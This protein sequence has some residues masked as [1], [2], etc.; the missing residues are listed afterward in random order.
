[1]LVEDDI[2]DLRQERET[3]KNKLPCEITTAQSAVEG[4]KILEN[5][6]ADLI[7]VS[8]DLPFV[9]GIKF[10]SLVKENSKL[11]NIPLIIMTDTR[12]FTILSE[13]ER[14]PAAGHIK[15]P[16]ITEEG[17][18]LIIEKLRGRK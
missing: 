1:M 15:K 17:L 9:N 12:D 8:L 16:A 13:I 4:M 3:L 6:G 14:S 10:L 7:L 2:F 5:R 11:K 18:A